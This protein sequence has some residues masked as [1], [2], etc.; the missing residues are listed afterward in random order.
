MKYKSQLRIPTTDQYAYI[1]VEFEGTAEDT[2]QAYNEFTN[3]VKPQ[4]GLPSKDFNKILDAYLNGTGI[5]ADVYMSM[6]DD[7]KMVIQEIKKSLKRIQAK[8]Q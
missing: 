6:G 4:E 8:Q 5:P 2:I 1:E 3:L 7:Q